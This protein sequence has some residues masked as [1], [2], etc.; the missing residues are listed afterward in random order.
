MPSVA[1]ILAG[2]TLLIW[3]VLTFFR[4]AF[5]QLRT[6]DDDIAPHQSPPVWPRVLCVMPAR[7]EAE[8]IA[9]A[10]TSLV[11]QEY[12]G[13][14]RVVVVDDHSDD[15][16]E[17]L[18]REAATRAGA[19]ISTGIPHALAAEARRRNSS[20]RSGVRATSMPPDSMWTPS[21]LN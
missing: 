20:S 15:D 19:M 13:E 14:L 10:V 18:A 8:A 4:G 12:P 1:L 6:F 7:N 2:L 5:W 16:T 17:E 3:I 11:K 9:R 21:S